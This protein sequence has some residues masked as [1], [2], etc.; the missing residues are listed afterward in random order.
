MSKIIKVRVLFH[1]AVMA[2]ALSCVGEETSS[3]SPSQSAIESPDFTELGLI[4]N[5]PISGATVLDHVT[6]SGACSH[7]GRPI[8]LTGSALPREVYS[9]C[10]PNFTW[11]AA[12]NAT[13]ISEG[14]FSVSAQIFSQDYGTSAAPV[15]LALNKGKNVCTNENSSLL[16]ANSNAGGDGS[17]TPF[18]I[19]TPEQFSNIRFFPN[20]KFELGRDIDFDSRVIAPIAVP[21]KGTLDGRGMQM[22]NIVVK[23]LTGNGI[24]VGLFKYAHGATIKDLSIKNAYVEGYQRVGIIAGDWRGAGALSNLKI[25]GK[26]SGVEYIGGLIGLGN[27]A[28]SL[29]ISGLKAEVEVKGN[30]HVGGLISYIVSNDGAF[31]L[32]DSFILSKVEG[33]DYVGGIIGRSLEDNISISATERVGDVF[34]YGKWIGGLIGEAPGAMF[35]GVSNVGNIASSKSA[36][37]VFVGGLIGESRGPLSVTD[38]NSV[39]AIS[40][41]G[42]YTGGIAGKVHSVNIQNTYTRG[43]ISVLDTKYD[44]VVKFAGGL[45]GGIGLD[46]T[47]NN[48]RSYA[49]MDVKA[50]YVGGLV[51]VMNGQNSQ[52]TNSHYKGSISAFTSHIGGLAGVF[53]GSLIEK[54]FSQTLLD[55]T[56]PTPA[57]NIGGI[58]GQAIN[59]AGNYTRLYSKSDITINNGIADT[60]GGAFGYL[61]GS[62]A[63]EIHFTGSINGARSKVGGIAGHSKSAISSSYSYGQINAS[64]RF[65]GGIVGLSQNANISDV[66]SVNMLQGKGEVGGLAGWLNGSSALAR[67]HF[68]GSIQRGQ[69]SIFPENTFGQIAGL[70]DSQVSEAY[71]LATNSL[72]TSEGLPFISNT[73]G[74]GLTSA[75][76]R[77]A[78]S[79][80][81]FSFSEGPWALPASGFQLP[82]TGQD[83]LYASFDWLNEPNQG[84]SLPEV[85]SHDPLTRAWPSIFIQDSDALSEL[86]QTQLAIINS[87]EPVSGVSNGSLAITV[88]SPA[89]NTEVVSARALIHGECGAVGLPVYIQGAINLTSICQANNRWAAV[90][91]VTGLAVGTINFSVVMKSLDGAQSSNTISKSI[92]KSNDLCEQDEARNGLFANSHLGADGDST[93]FKICH[94]GHFANMAFYPDKNFELVNDIDFGSNTIQPIQSVF[95]GDLNGNNHTI[96]NFIISR[97]SS[98][99]AGLFRI[100]NGSSIRDLKIVNASV[101]GYERVGVLAGSWVGQGSL[102][103]VEVKG[104]VEGILYTGGVI[105]LAN[106][107]VD[108]QMNQVKTEIIVKGNGHTGGVLGHI[109]TLDGNF[110]AS[111]MTLKNTVEGLNH[112][113]GLIGS[114]I[115]P[116][117]TFY[118]VIQTGNV[119]ARK[120]NVG[121]IAGALRGGRLTNIT[122]SG[123]I[124]SSHHAE[125]ANVGGAVGLVELT[126]F[127]FNNGSYSGAINGGGDNIGG[128][129]GKLVQGSVSNLQS[130]GSINVLDEKYNSVRAYVGGLIGNVT[131][132]SVMNSS[133]SDANINVKAQFAGGLVGRFHGENSVLTNSF[134]TGELSATTAFVGGI[135]GFFFGENLS[136]SHSTGAINVTNPTPNSYI[137]GLLGYANS[138]TSDFQRVYS[139]GNIT[140]SNGLADYVGGLIGYFRGGSL[141]DCY[142]TG[143]VAGARSAVGGLVGLHRG[144][145]Q[146]CYAAGNVDASFRHA[147]GLIGYL[148]NGSIQDSFA[149][150][151]VSAKAQAGG[152]LGYSNSQA[153]SISNVYAFNQTERSPGSEESLSEFGPIVGAQLEAGTVGSGAYYDVARLGASHNSEGQGI[154]LSSAGASSSYGGFDFSSANSWRM[155]DAGFNL[156]GVGA[157]SFP[158]HEWLGGGS[159]IQTYQISGSLIGLNYGQIKVDLNGAEALNLSAGQ[160]DFVFST[161]LSAGESYAVTSLTVQGFEAIECQVN[162]GVGMV[163]TSAVVDI[164]IVCPSLSSLSLSP[165]N[166]SIGVGATRQMQAM[167]ALSNGAQIDL[168]GEV[169]WSSSDSSVTIDSS[170][171]AS[172]ASIGS[173][174]L[175]GSLIGLNAG[176]TATVFSSVSSAQN[177]AWSESSPHNQVTVNAAWTPAVGGNISEQVIT[178]YNN[179]GCSGAGLMSKSLLPGAN[180][181]AFIGAHNQNY[182]FKIRAISFD[183]IFADS[184]CSSAMNIKLDPPGPVQNLASASAWFNGQ[185][186]PL[187]SWNPPSGVVLSNIKI[188]LGS[189]FGQDNIVSF[190][191]IGVTSVYTFQNLSGLSEC[192]PSFPVVKAVNNYG[193][194]SIVATD[195]IGFRYDNTAPEAVISISASG[196]ATES[197]SPQLS[198]AAPNDNCALRFYELAIGT[199][200]GA[201]DVSGG[202]KAIGNTT[203]YKAMSG[204]HGFNLNLSGG[205][206]YYAS[207][208][209]VD[210]AGN[211]STATS[212]SAWSLTDIESSLPQMAIWLD[213][214]AHE[215]VL[216]SQGLDAD[217]ASFNNRVSVW[218]DI[219][220]GSS[221]HHFSSL[222]SEG[223]PYFS[224]ENVF[225]NGAGHALTTP[226]HLELDNSIMNE[227]SVTLAFRTDSDI[228]STQVIYEEGGEERGLSVYISGSKVYCAFWNT[229]NDGDGA[230]SFISVSGNIQNYK[231]YALSWIF[232]YSNYTGRNG[233][234]GALS[235]HLNG[236]NLGQVATTSRIHPHTQGIGLGSKISGSHFHTGASSGDGNSFRG[237]F[238][239]LIINNQALSSA[240]ISLVDAYLKGKWASGELSKPNA[241]SMINN[242]QADRTATGSWQA[243]DPALFNTASYEVSLGTSPG[244][245]ELLYWTDIG[246]VNTYQIIDG[247]DGAS[248]SLSAGTDYYFAVRAIDGLGNPS[249]ASVSEPF[250]IFDF[251]SDITNIVADLSS[252]DSSTILDRNGRTPA[253]AGFRGE[254]QEWL[255]LSGLANDFF[256]PINN[257]PGLG[258]Q[259][260]VSFNGNTNYL[261]AASSTQ[262]NNGIF[263]QKAVTIIFEAP[264][265]T[266]TRQVIYE[267]G[268]SLRGMN[269]YLDSG[270]LYCGFWNTLDDGDG[271]QSFIGLSANIASNSQNVATLNLDYSN[272]GDG[273]DGLVSCHMN[274]HLMGSANTTSRLF[275][276][277]SA[278]MGGMESGTHFHTGAD[279][280]AKGH[281][282]GGQIT[283]LIINNSGLR[284][285]TIQAYHAFLGF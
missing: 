32:S 35:T 211:R 201:S 62:L 145:T 268:D 165:N 185:T 56:N 148:L 3:V 127:V 284:D 42:H 138:W 167:G 266:N 193:I 187:I 135:A 18:V 197:S 245:G 106:T 209:A 243:I 274:G 283:D 120:E 163:G 99:G 255:D 188:G 117:V 8:K 134:F 68:I 36:E 276:H 52:I 213:S 114:S 186:S 242:A 279:S 177:I 12:F 254:V 83:F 159:V 74:I 257:R 228:N 178:Y 78:L 237:D 90:L 113:G 5:S 239:E 116:N 267:Q 92:I 97:T 108:L 107:A 125:E 9:V 171:L 232:D 206:D 149:L 124:T 205:V 181:D 154:D 28:S 196:D 34:G 221:A 277:S 21:F 26:T 151:S 139:T 172:G 144:S 278:S 81:G 105:G 2:L 130:H 58:A 195:T 69:D 199:S 48:S 72:L 174:I 263:D 37:D 1:F 281:N 39:A 189:S 14:A 11:A 100:I 207:V 168:T 131:E 227:K 234:D 259:G 119:S 224:D 183:G 112:V 200:P 132:S 57:A 203:S 115:E 88:L 226:S 19:C 49:D 133:F 40:S 87:S 236:T 210:Y 249:L 204:L 202:F 27:T 46:S 280:G 220:S 82:F 4:I 251:A 233:A 41:G 182:T 65:I 219:S 30:K 225:F 94:A 156:P 271:V 140:I 104:E 38:S 43:S 70:A 89:T 256:S 137:G 252:S 64:L 264:A 270:K 238:Y 95:S 241:L 244:G 75:S 258:A 179:T 10:Q 240:Q 142:A 61:D 152:I 45:F 253:D 24:S 180:S 33:I 250:R 47:I 184:I 101:K 66:F 246:N 76:M 176:T 192:A 91:D 126:G 164:E 13:E 231:T 98:V 79:Y 229:K 170:G 160:G 247:T 129:I 15:A 50:Q 63:Q 109:S 191:S 169:S 162:N 158:I 85:F 146:R 285:D 218:Q 103:N 214:S 143:N 16:F 93:P 223:R 235:C 212:S 173:S 141:T 166:F 44:S 86:D 22:S 23:D 190:S 208:R 123:N 54:S 175:S 73:T 59:S 77:S 136:D 273:G 157:Y 147:G 198:W 248:I 118:N 6:I 261:V 121:G 71:F 25:S 262:M 282:F 155:P 265:D 215:S 217:S 102:S 275:P 31:S 230:Q 53:G 194:E 128:L 29:N 7:A 153:G 222:T 84:H 122:V 111:N 150:G 17:A 260:Q 67:G 20:S 60:V 80:T 96:R 269:L 51:G 272:F 55:V 110:T 216:D 161:K